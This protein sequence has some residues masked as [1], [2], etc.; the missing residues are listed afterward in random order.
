MGGREPRVRVEN[1]LIKS[2]QIRHSIRNKWCLV[3]EAVTISWSQ[4]F[5]PFR[6][7][8]RFSNTRRKQLRC[9]N[10]KE[11]NRFLAALEYMKDFFM[12]PQMPQSAGRT[13][14][15][16]EKPNGKSNG[17]CFICRGTQDLST[18]HVIPREVGGTDDNR[19]LMSLCRPCHDL[20]TT[21]TNDIQ[22]EARKLGENPHFVDYVVLVVEI[23]S[24][25]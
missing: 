3:E 9:M 24:R 10:E 17:C 23:K 7:R 2:H 16:H 14:N 19:N 18:H 1:G 13:A 4:N 25:L 6:V 12:S 11:Q 22:S 8:T 5:N 20:V 21:I 15:N